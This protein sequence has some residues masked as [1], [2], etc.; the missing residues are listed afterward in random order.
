MKKKSKNI[1]RIFFSSKIVVLVGLVLLV[2]VSAALVKEL[3]RKHKINEEIAQVRYKIER[4]EKRNKDLT[5]SIEYFSTDS[6]KEI[7]ARQSLNFQKEGEKA[8]A[9]STPAKPN[10]DTESE[11]TEKFE[12]EVDERSNAK[13][14]W[15]YFFKSKE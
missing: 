7:Q 5:A 1:W 12:N 11:I 14:W 9:I 6:Y 3:I 15:D 10:T 8:V 2:I 4:L 13:K